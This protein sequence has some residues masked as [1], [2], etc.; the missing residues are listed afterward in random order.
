MK[1]DNQPVGQHITYSAATYKTTR[2]SVVLIRSIRQADVKIN[3]S[4]FLD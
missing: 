2:T 3:I 4:D 1:S